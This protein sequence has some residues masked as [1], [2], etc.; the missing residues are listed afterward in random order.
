MV[1]VSEKITQEK[2]ADFPSAAEQ[3]VLAATARPLVRVRGCQI[4]TM[5]HCET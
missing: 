2:I 4:E 3:N 5:P 1:S